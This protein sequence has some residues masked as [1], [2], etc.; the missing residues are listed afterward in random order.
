MSTQ[1]SEITARGTAD[2]IAISNITECST[3]TDGALTIN[4]K[5]RKIEDVYASEQWKEEDEYEVTR[6]RLVIRNHI[7][8]HVKFIKGEG[9]KKT[10]KGTKKNN[11]KNLVFGK[12]HER[13]DLTKTSGYEYA[14]MDL[15]GLNDDK[16]T[17]VKRALYWKT[18]NNYIHK[19][20]RELRGRVN[21]AIKR[22]I[23]EGEHDIVC[24]ISF[25]S[26]FLTYADRFNG[27][28]SYCE[29][30]VTIKEQYYRE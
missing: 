9:A 3:D 28:Q 22:C 13:P 2:S 19:E 23:L 6:L 26:L 24:N 10:D 25:I 15:V 30:R 8:K 7:F 11:S 5:K 27:R 4:E 14:I 21:A 18:Y 20:I 12:C 29:W 1:M 17:L 16:A